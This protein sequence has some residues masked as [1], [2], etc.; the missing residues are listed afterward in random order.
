M[1][2]R[3]SRQATRMELSRLL[4]TALAALSSM[5]DP[6]AGVDDLDRQAI[7]LR[8]AGQVLRGAESSAPY[9]NDLDAEAP[10]GPDRPF[11][12]GLGGV[13][14]AHCVYCDGHHVRKMSLS[15]EP[16]YSL[17][18]SITS[19][20]LYLPQCGHTRC[21]SLGSWQLGHSERPAGFR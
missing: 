20:P 10:G 15:P 21:G 8:R 9:Q 16:G 13:V 7:G 11:D 19:R 5:V 12:F 18:T 14:A 4:R 2:S 1:P 6:L 17:A 3:T